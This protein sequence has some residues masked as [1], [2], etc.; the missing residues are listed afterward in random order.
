LYKDNIVL[1]YKNKVYM[2]STEILSIPELDISNIRKE[3]FLK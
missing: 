2:K 1:L 3:K